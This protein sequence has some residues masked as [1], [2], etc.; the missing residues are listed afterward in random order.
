MD[1]PAAELTAP[2]LAAFD[3][4]GQDFRDNPQRFQPALI[5]ASPGP[6]LMEGVP[7]VFVASY[8]QSAAVLRNFKAFSSLKPKGLPGM[9]RID[10]FN[11][12]PVMNYSDPP[13]HT[14]RRKVV[15]PAFA[16][17]RTEMLNDNAAILIDRVLEEIAAKGA[18]EAMTDLTKKLSIDVLLRRF[19]G[20]ADADQHIFMN[21]VATLPL[22]DKMRPGDP[23][24]QPYLDAWEEGARYCRR[25]QELARQGECHNLIGV[26]ADGAEGGAISDD[27]MMA[28]MIVLLIGGVS[29]VA[30]AAASSLMFLAQNPACADRLRR[31]PAAA[32]NHLEES[33]RLDPPVSMV[34]RFAAQ[35]A[36]IDG[37]PVAPG[38]PIYVLIAVACHDP[39]K[40]PDPH[41]FDIDRPNVKDH[42]AFGYGMHTCIGNA[43]TRTI[44]PL[45]VRK[46]ASRFPNLAV[47]PGP[48]AIVY[49]TSTPRARHIKQL[50]LT[51]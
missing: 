12:L 34:M 13:D 2:V 26:I 38:T 15:N 44:V 16:P 35:D 46:V 17:K 5:A 33:L 47:A 9:E 45:L 8:A 29:T 51:V 1:L 22:L 24:P 20:I 18:F 7:S 40:F 19:L 10:F 49:D 25:Q 32:D 14:R 50:H 28:M 23:K 37:K 39:A 3:P 27:E 6:I 48:D 30:G 11:G 4:F 31:D 43:I 21:Y 41:R 42:L 36:Q